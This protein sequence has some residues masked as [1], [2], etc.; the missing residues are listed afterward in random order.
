MWANMIR[1]LGESYAEFGA[2]ARS[3]HRCQGM[4]ILPEPGPRTAF[5]RL[6]EGDTDLGDGTGF[7]GGLDIVVDESGPA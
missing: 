4:N 5:F 2:R 7:F 1:C 6:V 3:S